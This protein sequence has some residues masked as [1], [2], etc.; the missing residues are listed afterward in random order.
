MHYWINGLTLSSQWVGC[1]T[2]AWQLL[3]SSI[4]ILRV[5]LALIVTALI[6]VLLLAKIKSFGKPV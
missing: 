5:A 3:F 1:K 6:L 4:P 2:V